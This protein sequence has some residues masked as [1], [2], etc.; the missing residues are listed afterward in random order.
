MSK[1]VSPASVS[2][3]TALCLLCVCSAV[4]QSSPSGKMPGSRG[5]DHTAGAFL[6]TEG[7][8]DIHSVNGPDT[9]VVRTEFTENEKNS[10]KARA[11]NMMAVMYESR[12]QQGKAVRALKRCISLDPSNPYYFRRLGLLL[13]SSGNSEEQKEGYR[14]LEQAALRKST[15][16]NIYFL[17]GEYF[18]KQGSTGKTVKYFERYI[19]MGPSLAE[20]AA[21]ADALYAR[22][23]FSLKGYKEKKKLLKLKIAYQYLAQIYKK[24]N[25]RASLVQVLSELSAVNDTYK[26][27]LARSYMH[28][29]TFQKA[30]KVVNSIQDV[31]DLSEGAFRD[32]IR[33]NSGFLAIPGFLTDDVHKGMYVKILNNIHVY[34]SIKGNPDSIILEGIVFCVRHGR[35]ADTQELVRLLAARPSAPDTVAGAVLILAQRKRLQTALELLDT[36]DN[37]TRRGLHRSLEVFRAALY[38][39]RGERGQAEKYIAA[40][41]KESKRDISNDLYARTAQFLTDTGY[42]DQ[43]A[44]F[45]KRYLKNNGD[46][47]DTVSSIAYAVYRGGDPEMAFSLLDSFLKEHPDEK[48]EVANIYGYLLALEKRNLDKAVS[49]ISAALGKDPDNAAYLDSLGW[50]YFMRGDMEKAEQY[51]TKAASRTRDDEIFLHLGDYYNAAGNTEKARKYWIDSYLIRQNR[52]VRKKIEKANRILK[53]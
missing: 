51:L 8:Q 13:I 39:A 33:L 46:L 26:I 48:G 45:F 15:Y 19:A 2:F 14:L 49:L 27:S 10:H 3:C 12:G 16:R 28:G 47:K 23:G 50:A 32:F 30:L 5:T 36:I 40:V 18:R 41:S 53:K 20:Q 11:S 9:G 17:L 21:K 42:F 22:E 25:D 29:H 31:Y 34:L 38:A 7:S 43:A 4:K 44:C 37:E 35:E 52:S 24:R 6:E 1:A